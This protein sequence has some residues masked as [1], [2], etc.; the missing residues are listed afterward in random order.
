M[1]SKPFL[2]TPSWLIYVGMVTSWVGL[3][4]HNVWVSFGAIGFS[5][6]GMVLL[7]KQRRRR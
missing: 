3:A 2:N 7:I 5:I 1:S 6:T 4:T